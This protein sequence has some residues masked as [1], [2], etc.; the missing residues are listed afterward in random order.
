[1]ADMKTLLGA[2]CPNDFEFQLYIDGV[3][4]HVTPWPNEEEY[5]RRLAS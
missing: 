1:M 2:Y 5:L 3:K 4:R